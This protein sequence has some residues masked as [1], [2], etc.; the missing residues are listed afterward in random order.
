[1]VKTRQD[2]LD[3][4]R[5]LPKA[6]LAT[7]NAMA[8]TWEANP[9]MPNLFERTTEC[10]SIVS[11]HYELVAEG[12]GILHGDTASSKML[13]QGVQLEET[14][15]QLKFNQAVTGLHPMVA[16]KR[17][18]LEQCSKACRKVLSWIDGQTLFMPKVAVMRAAVTVEH[19]W[20]AGVEPIASKLVQD[21]LLLL[22]SGLDADV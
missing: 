22:L 17:I 15:R 20:K 21:I 4:E 16:Q 8:I 3:Q 5:S 2:M 9:L 6:T 13:V 10:V 11:V 12:G 18:M 1:M 19:A 7:W 14:Q